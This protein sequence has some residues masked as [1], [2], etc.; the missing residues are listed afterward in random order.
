MCLVFILVEI[1]CV[2]F[3]LM[4]GELEFVLGYNVEYVLMFFVLFFL[5]EYV[6]IIFMSCLIVFLF[7]GG[8]LV[9]F[10]GLKVFFI[11]WFFLWV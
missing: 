1:N 5:V 11:V 9:F 2:L 8:W 4:E 3:D 7:F 10:F 6:Y